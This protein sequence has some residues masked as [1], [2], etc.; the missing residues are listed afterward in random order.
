MSKSYLNRRL[1]FLA[2]LG[3]SSFALQAAFAEPG[4]DADNQSA[5]SKAL[6]SLDPVLVTAQAIKGPQL[7]PSQGS[8]IATQPQSIVGRDFIQNN[9]APTANYT[10]IIK[11]TPSVWTVDPNGPG[12]M[13]NLGTSIRGFQDGQ[14]NVTFDGIPWGDSNDFTHHSTSYF[15]AWDVGN[16]IVDR[17]PGNAGTLGDATFGGTVYVQSD[18]PKHTM[19]LSVMASYGS[20]NTQVYG[21]RYDTGDVDQW[22]GTRAYLSL[23]T[24][25]SDGYLSNANLER[26]N[27]FLKLIQPLNDSTEITAAANLNKLRQNPPVGATPAQLAAF[28]ANYAY[29]TNPDSQ[30]Y[31]GYNLDV[32]STDYEYIGIISKVAGFTFDNKIYTYGYFHDG[33]NG[34]DVGGVLPNGATATGDVPN[35]TVNGANNVP[36]EL[37]INNYRSIGDIFRVS[38]DLGPGEVQ[39]GAWFDHQTNLRALYEVDFSDNLA[40]NPDLTVPT[41][42]LP[43]AAYTDRLQHNQLFTRQ[44][45]GQYV[46]HII[47]GLDMTAGDKYVNFQRVVVA[48]VN[49]GTQLPLNYSQT[50][51]RNLP[52]ADLHYKIMENWSAY[53][54]YSKGFLAPNL[55][56]LYVDDPGKNTLQPEATTNV[57]VGTTWVGDG[58]TVSADAYTIN[59]SN[60]IAPFFTTFNNQPV[61]QFQN[62]GGVKYKG[63]ELE[64]TY[65]VGMGFSVYANASYNI[66]RLTNDTTTNDTWV[67]LTPNRLSAIGLLY[68]QGA[69]QGSLIERYVGR[70]FGDTG[71]TYPLGGYGTADAA[72]NYYFGPWGRAVKDAK[73]GVTM[74]NITNRK[75][76]YFLNGYSAGATPPGYING[77]PM[78]FTLPGRSVQL[79]LSAS[80]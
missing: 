52:S 58:L 63:V 42:A 45:Y 46:W 17:G 4:A 54:Q 13:E 35:G 37:L 10:D 29:N 36:G 50:W 53:A 1:V 20:F 76:I 66:A 67:P 11:L 64:G 8:L 2:L 6:N 40:Y 61:K 72:V 65:V 26:S 79:N 21:V 15:M 47:P 70:R 73:V 33:Y 41:G 31:Y 57:Q 43:Q 38:H 24:M 27:A 59:Y 23:K 28:G 7:A 80:F 56:V 22:G 44:A 71:D 68:R 34:E 18:D 55:N 60:Q 19:G 3:G 62:L 14:F 49:Q 12:L 39:A 16:V 32:I 77:N 78:F 9:D 5:Q 30:G 25:S 48:P 51:T 74:E 75:S 69:W